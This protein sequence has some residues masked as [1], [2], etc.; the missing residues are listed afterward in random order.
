MKRK[1]L[2]I[3]PKSFSIIYSN[4]KFISYLT[5]RKGGMLNVGLAVIAALTPLE[6]KVKI[7]DE[8]LEPINFD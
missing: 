4:M 8:N 3:R 1:L 2:L 7:I 6:F 5:K